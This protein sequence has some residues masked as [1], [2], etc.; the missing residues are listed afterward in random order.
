M[1]YFRTARGIFGAA[2]LDIKGA[3]VEPLGKHWDK[4]IDVYHSL[5]V[6]HAFLRRRIDNVP[7]CCL[8]SEVAS[9][10]SK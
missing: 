4:S 7:L 9:V 6:H 10:Q 8:Y 5:H 3:V 2:A 1:E